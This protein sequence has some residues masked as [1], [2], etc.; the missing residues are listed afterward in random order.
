MSDKPEQP[1]G[2]RPR[3]EQPPGDRP[4]PAQPGEQ[5]PGTTEAPEHADQPHVAHQGTTNAPA[6]H[7]GQ[8]GTVEGQAG[9]EAAADA[10]QGATTGEPAAD[11]QPGEPQFKSSAGGSG[12]TGIPGQVMPPATPDSS[13]PEAA[14]AEAERHREQAAATGEVPAGGAG[15]ARSSRG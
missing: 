2:D 3:P 10:E 7:P 8:P 14:Q 6:L 1:P 12:G 5:Q 13:L 11:L 15:P 9:Q 4:R